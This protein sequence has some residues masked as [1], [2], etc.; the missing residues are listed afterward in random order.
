MISIGGVI[1]T[2]KSFK[3]F[4]AISAST[5]HPVVLQ[6]S[7]WVPEVLSLTVVLSGK[8]AYFASYWRILS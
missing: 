4:G 7:S 8:L 1:G 5:D 2:G 6:V 3:T